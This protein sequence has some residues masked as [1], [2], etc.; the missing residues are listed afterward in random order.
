MSLGLSSIEPRVPEPRRRGRVRCAR[1]TWVVASRRGDLVFLRD[2]IAG[3]A[4][5]NPHAFISA[6]QRIAPVF[7]VDARRLQPFAERRAVPG[8]LRARRR[9]ARSTGRLGRAF[10][11]ERGGDTR[12]DR[13]GGEQHRPRSRPHPDPQ[14]GGL[15]RRRRPSALDHWRCERVS[16]LSARRA[17]A[18]DRPRIPHHALPGA[19]RAFGG[20]VVRGA[21]AAARP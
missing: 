11:G 10:S 7:G 19:L 21:C 5:D 13:R 3:H 6:A 9:V 4:R 14:H 15:R 2:G 12:G 1:S 17:R 20:R 16:A 18:A 8:A